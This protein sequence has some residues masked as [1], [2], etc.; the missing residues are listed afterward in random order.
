MTNSAPASASE[1]KDAGE[2]DD[3]FQ[4]FWRLSEESPTPIE[5]E[6]V[7]R[8]DVPKI[9][10]ALA[11]KMKRAFEL[12]MFGV[13]DEIDRCG[14]DGVG[15]DSD[16]SGVNDNDC[17]ESGFILWN[18]FEFEG[19]RATYR[20][21]TRALEERV[22]RIK[23]RNKNKDPNKDFIVDRHP[24]DKTSDKKKVVQIEAA[25][26]E[27]VDTVVIVLKSG[28]TLKFDLANGRFHREES[29]NENDADGIANSG[30]IPSWL[31]DHCRR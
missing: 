12:I 7:V 27:D 21:I 15:D 9:G 29:D 5:S 2:V 19:G 20:N 11:L 13:I 22:Q 1:G 8:D 18:G 30:G 17:D 16:E 14:K 23:G 26:Q 24:Q 10:A 28:E 31:G 4:L 6:F 3:D 25:F